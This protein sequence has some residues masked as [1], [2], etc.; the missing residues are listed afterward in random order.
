MHRH[1]L[2]RLR[3]KKEHEKYSNAGFTHKGNNGLSYKM[4]THMKMDLLP[5]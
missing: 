1:Y 5:Y 2:I 3:N 4:V